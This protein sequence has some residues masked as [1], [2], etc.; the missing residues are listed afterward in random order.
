MK[1]YCIDTSGFSNPIQGMPEGIY[2]SLWSQIR[3]RVKA[4]VFATTAEVYEEL[5]YIP[6]EFGQFLK[7]HEPKIKLELGAGNWDY[8]TYLVYLNNLHPKYERFI[9]GT[10]GT[11][12]SL[13]MEDFSIVMLGKALALPVISMETRRA[14]NLGSRKF[15][16]PDVCDAEG[17]VHMTFNEMLIAEGITV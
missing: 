10:G 14:K 17:V 9:H 4:E 2:V 5:T 16:I 6:G 11:K 8:A 12:T 13:S 15:K 1:K 7:D 3:E